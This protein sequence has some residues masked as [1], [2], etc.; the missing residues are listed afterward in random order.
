[1]SIDIGKIIQVYEGCL[2]LLRAKQNLSIDS[3]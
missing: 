2:T 1:M 3:Q